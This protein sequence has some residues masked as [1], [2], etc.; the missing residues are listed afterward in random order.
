MSM[1]LAGE[2]FHGQMEQI[3]WERLSAIRRRPSA[4][5]EGSTEV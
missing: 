2:D 4:V 1:M 5:V 3:G